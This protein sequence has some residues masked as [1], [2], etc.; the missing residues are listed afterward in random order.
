MKKAVT[1]VSYMLLFG[2]AF[3][4]GCAGPATQ[5]P[6]TRID[7][8]AGKAAVEAAVVAE[9]AEKPG[10]GTAAAAGA[11]KGTEGAKTAGTAEKP[12][13][14][15]FV[16]KKGKFEV[17]RTPFGYVKREIKP[18]E[19]ASSAPA[20]GRAESVVPL[21]PQVKAPATPSE[22]SAGAAGPP[23][24]PPESGGQIS[25]DFD[26]ADLYAVIRTM[27]D[28]LK[29][30][31]IIEPGV[32]GKVTIHTAGRLKEADVF[33][34]F[35][36]TLEV[37]GLVAVKEGNVFRI[38][39]LRDA[40]RMPITSRILK[41][42]KDIPPE[43]RIVIQII[44]LKFISAQEVTKV[45]TPFISADGTIIAEGGS[46]TLLVIDKGI[47]IFKVLKLV[48]AFD[49]SVFERMSYRF[50]PLRHINTDEAGKLLREVLSGSKE[51]VKFIPITRLN[52]LLVASPTPDVFDRLDA[53]IRQL[54]IPSESAQPQIH[55]YSVKNGMAAELGETV[56]AIFSKTTE[57]TKVSSSRESV[58]SNPFA[59]G[60]TRRRPRRR[61]RPQRRHRPRRRQQPHRRE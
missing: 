42:A 11:E 4:I 53:F 48:E 25:F 29:I 16:D 23:P 57:V 44:P 22:F 50:Y 18:A 51:D 60:Y 5:T 2:V 55:I 28:M 34:V 32:T 43:E 47:N 59:K 3:L 17:G 54:D 7:D 49:V 24:G 10:T 31:Y 52:A 58:P 8:R 30:N 33:P 12:V 41:D 37:N 9:A 1:V 40:L 38:G 35:H 61:H 19:K 21:V 26:D 56:Q 14:K 6:Q 13:E 45:I 39:K 27:A 20:P 15:V 36:Q 46:N